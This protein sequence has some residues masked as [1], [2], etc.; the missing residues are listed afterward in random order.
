MENLLRIKNEINESINVKKSIHAY[1]IDS[2]IKTII[3]AYKSGRKTIWFGNGG[4]A[5]DAQHI[6]AEFV[7]K[8]EKD[9]FPL[10]AICLNTNT[11]TMTAISNDYS[12]ENIFSRQINAIA[13]NG[14]I[15]IGIS[16]SGKSKNIKNAFE[17]AKQNNSCKT[18]LMTGNKVPEDIKKFTDL[19]ITVSSYHTPRIQES[20]I[21]I[22][23]I[24]CKFV[25]EEIL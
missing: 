17:V 6:V 23:H 9:R 1:Q 2:A 11:S 24:I 4:S 20:H 15:I 18:I 16:T 10:P 12:Y 7:G 25:E 22:G 14:D 8:Y 3:E 21:L 5:S 19:E 13:Q